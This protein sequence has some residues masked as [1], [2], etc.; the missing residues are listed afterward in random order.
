MYHGLI[1]NEYRIAGNFRE[2]QFSQMVDL[3]HFVGLIFADA[4]THTH[5][6]LSSL[7]MLV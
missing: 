5:Y 7:L 4:C 3:Y 6:V 2:V 1:W